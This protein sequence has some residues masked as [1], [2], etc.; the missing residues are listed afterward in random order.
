M[1]NLNNPITYRISPTATNDALN[2]LFAA[3]W[4]DNVWSD[5][6]PVLSRSLAYVCAYRQDRLIG[7]V[8]L[9]WDGGIHAFLLDTTVHPDFRR[10]GI[11]CEL[12]T[13]AVQ[14]ARERGIAWLHVDYEPHLE[15][16]YRGCGFQH[17]EA[18]L[19]RLEQQPD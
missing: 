19:M 15:S 3:A 2:A 10:R 14:A 17:T 9:A 16:F 8:N 13:R 5:F 6:E 7:F 12:V 1:T 4:P 18:G 11:G